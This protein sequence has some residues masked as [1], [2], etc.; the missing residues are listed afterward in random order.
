LAFVVGAHCVASDDR[1]RVWVCAPDSGS[2]LVFADPFPSV[3]E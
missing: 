1:N 3:M 2:L